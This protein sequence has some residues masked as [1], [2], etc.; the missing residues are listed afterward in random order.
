M[1]DAPGDFRD[2]LFYGDNLRVLR[3]RVDADSVDLVY[4][5]PP[6]NSNADYNVLFAE[7]GGEQS[8]AQIT[9]FKDTWHWD[10]EAARNFDDALTSGVGRLD[11]AMD[12]L[13]RLLGTSDI[14]AYLAMMAPRLVELR[15]VMKPTASLY[16]HCD[17]TASHYLKLVLD[18]VFG[19]QNFRGEIVWRRTYGHGGATNFHRVHDVIF[20]YVRSKQFT[21]NEP[22]L[23]LDD[24]YIKSHYGSVDA[25]GRRYQLITAHAAGAGPERRFGDRVIAPPKGRHWMDQKTIDADMAAG[26]IVFTKSGMPRKRRYFDE[27]DGRPIPDVW[28]DI[29]PINSQAQE[30]LGY[31]TQ[32]P[33]ALL[34]RIIAASSNVGDV[35]LDPFCGCGTAIVAAQNLGR[36]WLGI[37]ITHLATS[38]IKARL[39]DGFSNTVHAPGRAF[40]AGRDYAVVG[41]PTDLAGARQLFEDN[42]FQFQYWAL[43]LVDCFPQEHKKGADKGIDGRLWFA[44]AG[45]PRAVILSVKGGRNVGVAMVRD[46][47]GVLDREAAAVGVLLTLGDPTGPMRAEAADAG[48]FESKG[49]GG[50]RIPRVQIF[51]VMELLAGRR[52]ELPPQTLIRSSKP[53]PRARKTGDKQREMFNG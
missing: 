7:K 14:M 11:Q 12:G 2:T 34:E 30:R 6:F 19:P 21:W 23:P 22:R 9:A 40:A 13:K 41:E 49:I 24:S 10:T 26:L 27:K 31:P 16:L 15:R 46:L 43:S 45:E 1:P 52:I 8:H 28:T 47:V 39:H 35:V 51:T 33:E 37:D 29:F 17:T 53:A 36:R 50:A 5:D 4:L 25:E 38:L 3:E 18:S 44:D 20:Y 48:F 42:A 32:K